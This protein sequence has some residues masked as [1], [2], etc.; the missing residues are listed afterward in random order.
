[1]G[2]IGVSALSYYFDV[3]Q[4]QAKPFLHRDIVSLPSLNTLAHSV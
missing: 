3:S 2:A 4:I 1:V